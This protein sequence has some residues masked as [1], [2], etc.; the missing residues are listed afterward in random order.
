MKLPRTNFFIKLTHS[1]PI[2]LLA[3]T[4]DDRN[5]WKRLS[6]AQNE[7]SFRKSST[8]HITLTLV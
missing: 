3:N 2:H 8:G 1:F 4:I 5:N 7:Y 6:V